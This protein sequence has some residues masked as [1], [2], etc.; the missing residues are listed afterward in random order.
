[1]GKTTDFQD[2]CTTLQNNHVLFATY[3]VLA[4]SVARD[5]V[6]C[7][8]RLH[9]LYESYCNRELT[10]REVARM[11]KFEAYVSKLCGVLGF[12]LHINHDPRGAALKLVLP[13]GQ[14]NDFCGEGYCV[15][16]SERG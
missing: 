12:G 13:N 11:N 9:H 5:L 3:P 4:E 1:M 16:T 8:G 6:R 2:F 15:P 10:A 14:T 7:A